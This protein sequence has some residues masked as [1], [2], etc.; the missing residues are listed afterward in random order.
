MTR[1]VEVPEG[2]RAVFVTE[3]LAARY[4]DWQG[5]VAPAPFYLIEAKVVSTESPLI[6]DVQTRYV[7]R[8]DE[9]EAAFPVATG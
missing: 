5:V 3:Q 2:C 6:I 9:V 7:G 8:T 4:A 1:L